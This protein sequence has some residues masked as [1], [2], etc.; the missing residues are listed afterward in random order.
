[1]TEL[2]MPKSYKV[3]IQDGFF[4]VV[5]IS[6]VLF[7]QRLSKASFATGSVEKFLTLFKWKRP[8][9]IAQFVLG[10]FFDKSLESLVG[11]SDWFLFNRGFYCQT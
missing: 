3:A 6:V 9:L 10:V 8:L 11:L 1:M 5:S 7:M 4:S 2:G